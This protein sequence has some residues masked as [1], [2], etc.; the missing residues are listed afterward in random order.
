M[1]NEQMKPNRFARMMENKTIY[2][3][4]LDA[5]KKGFSIQITTYTHSK[6]YSKSEQFKLGKSGVYVQ[7]GKNW[8]CIN[9]ASIRVI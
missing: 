7:R 6:I 9:G 2:E 3:K 5:I 8:D 4:I 1:T